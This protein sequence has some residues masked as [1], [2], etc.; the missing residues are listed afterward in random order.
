VFDPLVSIAETVTDRGLLEPGSRRLDAVAAA[1]SRLFKL[2]DACLADTA[3]HARSMAVQTGTAGRTWWVLPAGAPS[4]FR[5]LATPYERGCRMEFRVAY[6]GQY[7]PLHGVETMIEAASRL[8]LRDD[9][10]FEFVG[11]GQTLPVAQGLA[12]QL[13]LESVRFVPRWLS[14][15]ELAR[16]HIAVADLCLGVFGRQAKAGRV[17]P[18]KV[19]AGL[20]SGRAVITGDTPAERE[21]LYPGDEIWTTPVG[22][23]GALAEAIALMADNP[24]LVHRLARAGQ[25]AYDQRFA[26]PVLGA[27]LRDMLRELAI[28]ARGP[29]TRLGAAN[30]SAK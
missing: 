24:S 5:R 7:I 18:Y 26:A 12:A 15:E 14:P 6:F 20:A 22:D 28:P 10:V 27:R 2:P 17:V 4:V 21:L 19:Y 11:L 9:I 25:S 8:R 16:E 30:R 3:V 13:A 29:E 1:E 23:A